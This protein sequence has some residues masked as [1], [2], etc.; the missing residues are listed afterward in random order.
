MIAS[1][2]EETLIDAITRLREEGFTLDFYATADGQLGCRS[3][4]RSLD[5]AE[6]QLAQR[7]RFEGNS[8]PADEAVL[9][10][11]VCPCGAM[12]LYSAAYGPATPPEDS[13][14]LT[15]FAQRQIDSSPGPSFETAV[16]HTSLRIE[17]AKCSFCFNEAIDEVARTGG[18]LK[19]HGTIAG[20]TIDISHDNTVDAATLACI[21][22]GRMRGIELYANEIRMIPLAPSAAA[23]ACEHTR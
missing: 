1:S 15:R 10:A 11:L 3:C 14:V 2:G 21:V 8:N 23:P 4:T 20:P 19:V 5:P 12:G 6:M 9:L 16:T 22:R 13:L 7:V 18:V 17:G